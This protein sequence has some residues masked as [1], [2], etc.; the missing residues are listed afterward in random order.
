MINFTSDSA[1]QNQPEKTEKSDRG[2]FP[3]PH[4]I[5]ELR[6]TSSQLLLLI[7]LLKCVNWWGG[8][9]E[10]QFRVSNYALHTLTGLS[11]PT[12]IAEKRNLR[13]K[14]LIDFK[15][16]YKGKATLYTI[17]FSDHKVKGLKPKQKGGWKKGGLTAKEPDGLR[18]GRHDG[19]RITPTG[20]EF[21]VSEFYKHILRDKDGWFTA[22]GTDGQKFE[23][24]EDSE[25]TVYTRQG[26]TISHGI[27]DWKKTGQAYMEK[28]FTK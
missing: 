3:V 18:I 27:I 20:K 22:I 7:T 16:G 10:K 17:L 8:K 9:A 24:R 13:E 6:L 26:K 11:E 28:S 4:R 15:G 23:V 21:Y 5:Y 25:L 12:I 2:R 14:K 19:T 1:Q